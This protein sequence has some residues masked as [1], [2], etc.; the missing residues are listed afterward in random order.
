VVFGQFVLYNIGIAGEIGSLE[1]AAPVEVVFLLEVVITNRLCRLQSSLEV[2]GV[3]G[4]LNNYIIIF[5]FP[6]LNDTLSLVF[7]VDVES[8]VHFLCSV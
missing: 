6:F 3:V 8:L 7:V 4:L 2:E 5:A 1:Q